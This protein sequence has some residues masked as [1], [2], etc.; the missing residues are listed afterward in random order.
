MQMKSDNYIYC[1]D[2]IIIFFH[3]KHHLIIMFLRVL[4]YIA[5]LFYLY[6][7]TYVV[8]VLLKLMYTHAYMTCITSHRK[9]LL[10]M[11][12]NVTET[13]TCD[14]RVHCDIVRSKV[15]SDYSL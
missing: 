9:V 5:E 10:K 12:I 3:I 1:N 11:I 6:I 8:I 14:I 13:L 7:F 2:C 4:S 15:Q